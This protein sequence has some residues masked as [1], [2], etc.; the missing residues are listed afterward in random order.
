MEKHDLIVYLKSQID[1]AMC[2]IARIE[3]NTNDELAIDIHTSVLQASVYDAI[4]EYGLES[5][6]RSVLHWI[7]NMLLDEM[8]FVNPRLDKSWDIIN[9]LGQ[10]LD[11]FLD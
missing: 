7:G 11:Y 1:K 2:E 5:V 4:N 8:D 9:A 3:L 10:E 6:T